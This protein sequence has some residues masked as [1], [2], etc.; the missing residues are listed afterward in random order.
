VGAQGVAAHF[1]V[2]EAHSNAILELIERDAWI[3]FLAGKTRPV[4]TREEGVL[5]FLE[6]PTFW[7]S[8]HVVAAVFM[9]AFSCIPYGLGCDPVPAQAT[10]KALCELGLSLARHAAVSCE[11]DESLYGLLHKRT[12]S[13]EFRERVVDTLPVETRTRIG[14]L[15]VQRLTHEGW[16]RW[17]LQVVSVRSARTLTWD[18]DWMRDPVPSHPNSML[19]RDGATLGSI[20]FA[21]G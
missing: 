1:S 6:V 17:P 3:R 11:R 10:R 20:C 15:E 9:G 21:T 19:L 14:K 7:S 18:L 16:H 2:R 13:R 8:A 4:W 12:S 5:R